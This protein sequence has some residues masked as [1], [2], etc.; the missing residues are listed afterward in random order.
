MAW[1][2]R[3]R[4][5]IAAAL[6]LTAFAATPGVAAA[7]DFDEVCAGPIAALKGIHQQIVAHNAK[8]RL[9]SDRGYVAA[10]NAEARALNA[11]LAQALSRVRQCVSAFSQ[12]QKNYPKSKLLRPTPSQLKKLT[13]AVKNLTDAQKRAMSRGNPDSYDFLKYGPGKKGMT[14]RVDRNPSEIQDPGIRAVYEALDASRPTVPRTTYLQGQLPPKIGA[15]DPAYAN[16]RPVTGVAF[17]HIIPLRRLV[18][19]RDFLKLT[20]E[21]MWLVANSPANTQWLSKTANGS[22]LSGSSAF[23]T[24]ATPGWLQAQALLREKAEREIQALI[25]ALLKTQS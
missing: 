14:S 17:D 18:T 21:N 7:G 25:A 23:I 1:T 12:V 4:V 5:L 2:T 20:P 16:G 9:S 10:Y 3:G 13:P 22:K 15:P 6:G 11:R 24:G 19:Q 8:P